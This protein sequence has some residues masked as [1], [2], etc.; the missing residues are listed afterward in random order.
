MDTFNVRDLGIWVVE[1]WC[2]A[3]FSLKQSCRLKNIGILRKGAA[4]DPR[5]S[6]FRVWGAWGSR[7]G[8][9]GFRVGGLGV[10]GLGY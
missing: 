5:I 6:G 9:L 10:Q 4:S 7:F 2:G 1:G 8:V 3:G